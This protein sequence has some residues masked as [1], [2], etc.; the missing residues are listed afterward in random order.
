MLPALAAAIIPA[1]AKLGD[2]LFETEGEKR[3]F[4]LKV[5]ELAE[6]GKLEQLR[7]NASEAQ[8][9]SIFVAGWRPWV[10]WVCGMALAYHFIGQPVIVFSVSMLAPDN[11]PA[12]LPVLDMEPMMTVLLGMLGMAGLR[13]FEKTKGV[14]K[15]R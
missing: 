4:R 6:A 8:H 15:N 3:D 5:L 9:E 11:L 1:L 10:G 13:T 12:E 14:N 2:D 7:V